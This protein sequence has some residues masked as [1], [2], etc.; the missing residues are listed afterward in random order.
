MLC[1]VCKINKAVKSN[2][3]G[4]LPCI[5]CQKRQSTL[6]VPKQQVEFTTESIKEDRL[7]YAEDIIQPHRGD[8]L[9]K[10]YVD[11]YG[12][13]GLGNISDEELAKA[14]PVWSKDE[15]YQKY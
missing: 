14:E 11:R 4:V 9:S 6:Q 13:K 5:A 2:T 3:F 10:E 12:K 7:A 15:Y 1:L 8:T